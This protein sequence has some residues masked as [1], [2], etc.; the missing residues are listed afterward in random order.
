MQDLILRHLYECQNREAVLVPSMFS[1]PILL[2][3]IFRLG[4]VMKAQ[5]FTTAPVRRLGG[6]HMKLLEAGVTYCETSEKV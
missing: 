6:W 3:N 2:S 1:P 5:K 4:M